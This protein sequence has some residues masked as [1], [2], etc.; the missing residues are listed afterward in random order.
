MGEGPVPNSFLSP[1]QPELACDLHR[2]AH[3]CCFASYSARFAAEDVKTW[4]FWR[5]IMVV[6]MSSRLLCMH[7]FI[8]LLYFVFSLCIGFTSLGHLH[9]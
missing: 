9:L 8:L 6:D 4:H 7:Y 1:G 5:S 2:Q 3:R